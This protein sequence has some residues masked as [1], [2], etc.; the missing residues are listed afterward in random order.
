ML[1]ASALRAL[2]VLTL[3]PGPLAA[4][5][6]ETA[7]L[8]L[9]ELAAS[10]GQRERLMR[11]GLEAAHAVSLAGSPSFRVLDARSGEPLWKA[12][13]QGKLHVVAHGGPEQ[14]APL[15][16]RI[17]AGAFESE[18]AARKELPRLEKLAG[19]A[20]VVQHDPDR[21]TWRVRLGQEKER[22]ALNP[23]LERLRQ[24]GLAG[25]WIA[26]EAG[27]GAASTVLRLVD[28][29]YE[30]FAASGSRLIAVP[31]GNEPLELDGKP[32]RGV[33]EL[34]LNASGLVQPINW[35]ELEQYLLGVVP[36]ELGPEIWPQLPA[37]A[38]QAVAARTYAWRN[39]GQFEQQGFDLCASAR[40]QVYGGAS[41]E[42]AM[43]DRAVWDTR[44]EILM[45]QAVPIHALYTATCGGHTE[46]V[47]EIFPD[48][49]QEPYLRGVP[50]RAEAGGPGA[51][52]ASLAG[53]SITPLL[54][55]SG[56][57][58]TRDWALL[59]SAEVLEQPTQQ[60]HEAPT[61]A[62]LRSWTRALARLAGRPEPA[63][64]PPELATLGIAAAALLADMGW[65]ER[66][67]LLLASEDVAALLRDPSAQLLPSP[68]R[69]ALAYLVWVEGLKPLPDGRFEAGS[70][71]TCARLAPALA[72]IGESY[73]A[74]N[75]RAVLFAGLDGERLR[76]MEG[77]TEVRL[78]LAPHPYLFGRAG[79]R[80]VSLARLDLWPGD[81]LRLRTDSTGAVDFLE[82][83]PPV[84]GTADD[85]SVEVFSWEVR[86][87]RRELE[88][89][90]NRRLSVGALKELQVVRRGVSG[91]IVELRVVGS[92]G[93]SLVRGFDLR[94]L[95]DLRELPRVVEIQNDRDGELAAAVFAGK[96][97]GHGVGLCQVGAY[98]MALRGSDYRTILAH[99][100]RGAEL[101][102]LEAEGH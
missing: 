55:E 33:I 56:T 54:D 90:I 57:D 52:P 87:S 45:W 99:Y 11:V 69:S 8:R 97:W 32:Y 96:G 5:S 23:Y 48:Q 9:R 61:P 22:L 89:A 21:G 67:R 72:R 91:R 46:N 84:K 98:G 66:A 50:C 80:Q 93:A 101:T 82:L 26:E 41:I 47:K 7:D 31:D 28:A 20:G 76:L 42:H 58:V 34:R 51:A 88:A 102:R 17:Q 37:L 6:A 24:A 70:A 75:L 30:S 43:S 38:A 12:A 36:A 73:D 59:A 44:G 4:S 53:R 16:Y 77:K 81:R 79:G 74:F 95:L 10:V 49:A 86:K 27:V 83:L 29:S 14:G 68:E 62:Q 65:E 39:R 35:V 13:F 85:R 94:R 1:R 18:E 15:V 40:C 100:Y 92:D 60:A 71:P 2:T 25:L 3:W 63:G 78:P 64:E 19:V